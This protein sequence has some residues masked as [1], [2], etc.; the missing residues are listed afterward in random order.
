M[1]IKIHNPLCKSKADEFEIV[2]AVGII[3]DNALENSDTD[4]NIYNNWS[5]N[6]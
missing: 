4:D 2:D 3:I 5:E 1:H 6:F